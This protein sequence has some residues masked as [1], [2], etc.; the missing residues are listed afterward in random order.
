MGQEAPMTAIVVGE[1]TPEQKEGVRL[2]AMRGRAEPVFARNVEEAQASLGEAGR[3]VP[4]CILLDGAAPGA[5]GFIGWIRGEARL[6]SVPV[7]FLV[8]VLDE[9]AFCEAHAFGADDVVVSR[10][11]E[12]I[13][14][15]LLNLVEF[16]PEARPPLTQGLALVAH[17]DL[18]RRRVLGRILRQAGFDVSFAADGP[19]LVRVAGSG[20][21]PALVVA[22][23]Q[24][25]AIG[26]VAE[27]RRAAGD[28]DVPFVILGS[29]RDLRDLGRDADAIG[30]VA[31]TSELAPPD[32]LLFLANELMRPDVK[33]V[34]AS[35]R[36]LFGTLCAF[37]PEGELVPA[38]GLTYNL[39]REGMYVRTLDAPAPGSDVWLELRPPRA[40]RAVHLTARV[41]WRRGLTTA[42]GGA[43]PPGFGARILAEACGTKSLQAYHE[44]YERLRAEPRVFK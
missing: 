8:P 1:L 12:G 19:E 35:A 5:E 7:V 14:R 40:T 33:N 39:G 43:A 30:R 3:P 31:V 9:G 22:S 36:L 44:G 4:R 29:A 11:H 16:D 42:A 23:Q 24:L 13:T 15:R 10:D 38:Y 18:Q 41:V 2:A 26:L 28:A 17:G 6:F 25:G 21:P 37:R 34:R 27:T 32:N 20:G